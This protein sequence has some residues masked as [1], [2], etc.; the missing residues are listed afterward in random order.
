MSAVVAGG[1]TTRTIV[2]VVRDA[3]FR[4]GKM[5]PGLPSLALRD[6]VPPMIYVP[7]AQ[8]AGMEA[9]G[10]TTINLSVRSAGGSPAALAPSIGAAL[11]AVDPD[12]TFTFRP[13]ADY[14]NAS[15]AQERMVAMLSGFFGMLASLLAGLGLYGLTA[16]AVV[17]RRIEIGIRMALGAQ[18]L[19][20]LGLVLRKTLVLTAIG[21]VVGLAAAAAVTRYLQGMLFGLTALDPAT[22]GGVALAFVLVSALAAL[23]PARRATRVD[24]LIA[25]R[26]E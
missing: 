9:P 3:V 8:S 25:L 1:N 19:D 12:I 15:L 6:G 2:G 10:A 17:R 5:I 13:L 14:V 7:L 22:F 20:V 23:I 16:Y 26:S 11:A 21:I 4:S 24:P 18:R